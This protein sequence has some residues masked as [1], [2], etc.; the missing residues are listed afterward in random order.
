MLLTELYQENVDFSTPD[1]SV[2]PCNIEIEEAI[3]GGIIID[4][5]AI[6]RVKEILDNKAFFLN[7][8]REIYK[9]CIELNKQGLTTDLLTL[10]AYLE[11]HKLLQA[12]GGRSKLAALVDR[13][14]SA[15]NI[16]C[17]ANSLNELYKRREI[18]KLGRSISNLGFRVEEDLGEIQTFITEKIESVI[19]S[20]YTPMDKQRWHDNQIIQELK[21]IN[22]SVPE[23]THRFLEMHRLSKKTGLSIKSLDQLYM[24]ALASSSTGLMSYGDLKKSV[25]KSIREWLLNG[26][27]PKKSSIVLYADGG[28]GK[29]KLA[30]TLVKT[31]IQGTNWGDFISTGSKRKILIYQGDE[32][33]TDTLQA[34][35]ILGYSEDDIQKYVRFHFGWSF[36]NI[37]ALIRDVKEFQPDLIIGDSITYLQRYSIYRESDMEYAR[38]LLEINGLIEEYGFSFVYIHHTNKTDGGI[39][40]TT[41][42]RNAVSEVWSLARSTQHGHTPQDRILTIDKSRSSSSGRKYH[43]YFNPED[44][45][46]TFLGELSEEYSSPEYNNRKKLLQFFAENRNTLYTS[47][48]IAHLT[49]ISAPS[50]RRAL[51]NLTRDGLINCK[52]GSRRSPNLYYL[53]W[54]GDIQ[55]ISV[56]VGDHSVGDHLTDHQSDQLNS[57]CTASVSEVGD[58]LITKSEIFSSQDDCKKIAINRSTD[59]QLVE[60]LP[61]NDSPVDHFGDHLTDHQTSDHQIAENKDTSVNLPETGNTAVKTLLPQIKML[62]LS[63]LGEV[64]AIASPGGQGGGYQIELQIPGMEPV[65]TSTSHTEQKKVLIIAKKVLIR[66]LKSIRFQIHIITAPPGEY[67]WVDAELIDHKPNEYDHRKDRWIFLRDG[68]EYAIHDLDL[69]RLKS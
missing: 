64:R 30:Y 52:P 5:G 43:T 17:L 68:L 16:D 4:L 28:V 42:I 62:L 55:E 39:R 38:P 15:V 31:I 67:E 27:I 9:A 37:P 59:H 6:N 1:Q 46:F 61:A 8:H 35:E 41:A 49:G 53:E 45:S 10:S 26:L 51:S 50:I 20:G 33:Q 48:A 22:T 19:K 47:D 69:I 32:S 25:G 57:S 56:K 21:R 54:S 44:L 29:T 7:T 24:K 2:A 40:G 66:N 36:D 3:L 58:Q 13:T 63:P 14:V 34:L 12:V 11:R 65:T 18:I 60:S 23:V